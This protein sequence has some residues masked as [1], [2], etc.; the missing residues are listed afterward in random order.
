MAPPHNAE[1]PPPPVSMT[2]LPPH[3]KPFVAS[4]PIKPPVLASDILREEVA[5]IHPARR[6]IRVW[7]FAFSATFALAAIGAKLGVGIVRS[8]DDAF[9]GAVATSALAITA[10]I[11]P[12]RYSVRAAL[13]ALTGLVPLALGAVGLGPLAAFGTEG[14]LPSATAIALVTLLPAALVF[15]AR[16]RAFAGARTAV[17]IAL[18]A[19]VPAV[20]FLAMAAFDTSVP[21]VDRAASGIAAASALTALLG[22][23]GPETS[24]GCSQWAAIIVIAHTSRLTIHAIRAAWAGDAHGMASFG[25]AALGELIASTLVTFAL[26]QILAA[27]LSGLARQVDVHRIVGASAPRS[28]ASS[29]PDSE[30]D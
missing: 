5:P 19:S 25:A 26:F 7:L 4:Q 3:T 21:S 23:M 16:Y 22:F 12:L 8:G 17:G 11:V 15:R 10:A 1:T 18:A 2:S 24:A 9:V 28:S 13:A 20:A 30:R 27:T 14:V 29:R 6:A